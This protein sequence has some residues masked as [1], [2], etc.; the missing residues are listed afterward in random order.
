[1]NLP[2]DNPL[3]RSRAVD[4]I[5]A[6]VSQMGIY[7]TIAV[8]LYTLET[9][10]TVTFP[11][12]L[13]PPKE[14]VLAK[15]LSLHHWVKPMGFL[16]FAMAVSMAAGVIFYSVLRDALNESPKMVWHSQS[17]NT[18][19]VDACMEGGSSARLV[20]VAALIGF[21]VT[22]IQHILKAWGLDLT[23]IDLSGFSDPVVG[24]EVVI[25]GR[26]GEREIS[27]D[28]IAEWDGTLN[29][30]VLCRISKRVVRVYLK[31]GKIDSLKTLLGVHEGS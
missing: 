16:I 20:S 28:D 6:S 5:I 27:A 25:F 7:Q 10:P 9:E 31:S 19:L 22:F 2:L 26:Q 21:A 14:V 13:A 29:Y 15:D 4:R 17:A 12:W 11:G 8:V 23:M 1:M 30:E 24:E 18:K 3:K